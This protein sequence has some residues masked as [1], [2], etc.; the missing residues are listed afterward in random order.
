MT[1]FT[2]RAVAAGMTLLLAGGVT[3][4]A[5]TI[6]KR[7][8]DP[9]RTL[10]ITAPAPVALRSPGRP[11]CQPA[12]DEPAQEKPDRAQH[13]GVKVP[14]AADDDPTPVVDPPPTEAPRAST[15][16]DPTPTDEPTP[17]PPVGA[18][19][20]GLDRPVRRLVVVTGRLRLRLR[21]LPRAPPRA[22]VTS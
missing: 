21:R 22:R 5:A 15:P 17:P 12:D 10:V 2:E 4:G 8:S 1:S 7:G 9:D 6:A 13:H 16:P 20:A 11:S 19:G 3:V 14:P 18:A